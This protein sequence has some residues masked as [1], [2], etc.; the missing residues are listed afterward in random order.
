VDRGPDLVD[1]GDPDDRIEVDE[2]R[3]ALARSS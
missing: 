3:E 2:E 1:D